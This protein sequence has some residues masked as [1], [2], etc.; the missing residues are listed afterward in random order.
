MF[1][2]IRDAQFSGIRVFPNWWWTTGPDTIQ[3]SDLLFNPGT[4]TVNSSVYA[5]LRDTVRRAGEHGLVVDV[6]FAAEVN[7]Y[8]SWYFSAMQDVV[9]RLKNDGTPNVILDLQNEA[10]L[11]LPNSG[12]SCPTNCWA[13]LFWP[14]KDIHPQRKMMFS[15]EPNGTYGPYTYA[16]YGSAAA[17]YTANL[18]VTSPVTG[19]TYTLDVAAFHD[20]RDYTIGNEWWHTRTSNRVGD[21]R[22]VTTDPVYFQEPDR[23]LAS[24]SQSTLTAANFREAAARAKLA[25]AAAW[26]FHTEGGFCL[27]GV[28]TGLSGSVEPATFSTI[29]AHVA[30]RCS[31]NYTVPSC[32]STP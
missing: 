13:D 21:I 29:G 1:K 4:G 6:S 10:S 11:L 30:A 31:P 8:P 24:G 18:Q 14:L 28:C 5:N 26:T 3:A 2:D 12:P 22:V 16:A 17:G 20:P 7:G 25:G 19:V 9:N 32:T 27:S 15:I 23:W